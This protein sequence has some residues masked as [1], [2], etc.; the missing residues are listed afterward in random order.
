MANYPICTEC[1]QPLR[2]VRL[3]V[4]L[5]VFKA[6]ILDAI[7]MAGDIGISSQELIDKF[8]RPIRVIA[9]KSHIWQINEILEDVGWRIE[10]EGRGDNARWHLVKRRRAA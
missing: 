6:A 8:E 5:P 9:I 1:H 7:K 4:R 10:P 2:E 3:G